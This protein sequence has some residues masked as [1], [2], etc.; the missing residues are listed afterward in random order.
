MK[1]IKSSKMKLAAQRKWYYST[2]K[3]YHK[4]YFTNHPSAP[5]CQIVINPKLDKVKEKFAQLLKTN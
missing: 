4:D 2:G 3:D 1:T 5:Y